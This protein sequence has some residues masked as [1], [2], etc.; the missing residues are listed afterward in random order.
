MANYRIVI[1]DDHVMVRTLL[2]RVLEERTDFEIVGEVGDG[3]ELLKKLTQLS[4]HMVVLDIS[5]PNLRGIE[6]IHK[7][8][9]IDPD[10]KVLILTMH[11]SMEFLRQAFHAGANGYLLKED[12]ETELFSAIEAIRAGKTYVSP[13]LSEELAHDWAQI[14]RGDGKSPFDEPLSTREREVLKLIAEGKSNQKVAEL[15]SISIH[16]VERHRANMMEKLNINKLADLIKYAIQK[17]YI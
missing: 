2:K 15:L 7:I 4:P 1:A 16:T 14:H 10:I 11:K 13:L 12:D 9:T 17:G 8:K 5:M 6:V 3:F